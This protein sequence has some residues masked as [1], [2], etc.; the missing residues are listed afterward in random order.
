MGRTK[1]NRPW[2]P[3]RSLGRVKNAD[4]KLIK[5]A[6]KASGETFTAWAMRHLLRAAKRELK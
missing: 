5:R 1:L 4:W 2:H 3:S 6:A